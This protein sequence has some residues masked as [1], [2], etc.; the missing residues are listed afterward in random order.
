MAWFDKA[1]KSVQDTAGKAAFEADK[2]VRANREASV[3]SEMQQKVQGKLVD[4]GEAALA[5]HK[6]GALADPRVATLAAE[7][8]ELQG[9]I[10]Q[11]KVKVEAIRG[12]QHQ[13]EGHP[14]AAAEAPAGAAGHAEAAAPTTPAEPVRA[15]TAG[16]EPTA[17]TT[18]SSDREPF[19]AAPNAPVT[20]GPEV[21]AAGAP[22]AGG[23]EVGAPSAPALVECPQCHNRVKATAVFCPECGN[24][25]R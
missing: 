23:P 18:S 6:A 11:Q 7:L 20:G 2:L 15:E 25:L 12:E 21:G 8:A 17:G 16:A 24:H 10:E 1:L 9:Q 13:P 5:L 3:L 19:A 22:V 4:L 14:G